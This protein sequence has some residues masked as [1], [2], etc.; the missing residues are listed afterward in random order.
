MRDKGAS[1]EWDICM[2]DILNDKHVRL[3]HKR[4]LLLNETE[5]NTDI[6]G[7]RHFPYG[8]DVSFWLISPVSTSQSTCHF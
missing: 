4:I 6:N 7:T 8:C 3:C 2:G 5:Q 1:I